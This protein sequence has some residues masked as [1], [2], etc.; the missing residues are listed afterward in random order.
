MTARNGKLLPACA[1]AV[2]LLQGCG[3]SATDA[4]AAAGEAPLSPATAE[5]L[6][7]GEVL[8]GKGCP[9]LSA[10]DVA[11]V[12]GIDVGGITTNPAMECLYA[13]DGGAAVLSR[14]LVH[15]SAEWAH[16]QYAGATEDLS[17][18]QME[19]GAAELAGLLGE[20]AAAGEITEKQAGVGGALAASQSG[21]EV[22]N[23]DVAGIWDEASHDGN[24]IKVRVGN[25]IFDVAADR[26]DAFD[27]E[28]S[29]AIATRV[30]HNL[31]R[32]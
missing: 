14:P 22:R 3:G 30:V 8:E 16:T 26:G 25:V 1:L 9:L 4:V 28:L 23:A 10:A 32:R 2:A 6:F 5:R 19:A 27:L 13:W 20:K 24:R 11:A 17:P 12:A 21:L 29:R 15:R 18:A 31:E 7:S